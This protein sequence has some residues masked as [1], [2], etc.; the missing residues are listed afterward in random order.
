MGIFITSTSKQ[1][2]TDKQ[3]SRSW[4]A[5]LHWHVAALTLVKIKN[6]VYLNTSFK[7]KRESSHIYIPVGSKRLRIL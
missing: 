5:D 2:G 7:E 3:E 4:C 1:A 6:S